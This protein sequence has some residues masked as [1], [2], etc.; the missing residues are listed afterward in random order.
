MQTARGSPRIRSFKLRLIWVSHEIDTELKAGNVA[1]RDGVARGMAQV[2]VQV[3][4]KRAP[5]SLL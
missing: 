5:G 4:R 1:L 3:L 2:I